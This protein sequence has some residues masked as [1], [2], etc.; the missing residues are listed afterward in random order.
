MFPSIWRYEL[1]S[2]SWFVCCFRW[3][4]LCFFSVW[5]L[6][7][8]IGNKQRITATLFWCSDDLPYLTRGVFARRC[9]PAMPTMV[10]FVHRLS[11]L[12]GNRGGKQ[13]IK[14]IQRLLPKKAFAPLISSLSDQKLYGFLMLT[15]M[16]DLAASL[17]SA[18]SPFIQARCIAYNWCF[19]KYAPF[20]PWKIVCI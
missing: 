15:M 3:M 10:V 9:P 5:Q 2:S 14:P 12:C 8:K 6:F 16:Q 18:W 19:L 11:S 1:C 4:M 13:N 20:Y 7:I 17:R